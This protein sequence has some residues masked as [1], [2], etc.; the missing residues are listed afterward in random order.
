MSYDSS[1]LSTF[2]VRNLSVPLSSLVS[3]ARLIFCETAVAIKSYRWSTRR[4]GKARKETCRTLPPICAMSR[5]CRIIAGRGAHGGELYATRRRDAKTRRNL[6]NEISRGRRERGEL[7]RDLGSCRRTLTPRRCVAEAS[8]SGEL[9]V[10]DCY[11]R[12]SYLFRAESATSTK[13]WKSRGKQTTGRISRSR[14][15]A[16]REAVAKHEVSLQIAQTK[17]ERERER[18]HFHMHGR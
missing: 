16:A 6:K 15:K 12:N 13:N 2:R 1:V 11:P 7:T 3:C 9:G 4:G 5:V 10:E 18:G 17:T 8:W 14:G